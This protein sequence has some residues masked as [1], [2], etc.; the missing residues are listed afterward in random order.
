MQTVIPWRVTIDDTIGRLAPQTPQPL[1][2]DAA[3][4]AIGRLARQL[5]AALCGWHHLE[6]RLDAGDAVDLIVQVEACGPMTLLSQMSAASPM[7]GAWHDVGVLAR[8]CVDDALLS[9]ALSRLWLEFDLPTDADASTELPAPSVFTELTPDG[10]RGVTQ[11][12]RTHAAV[13]AMNLLRADPADVDAFCR[14][15][16]AMP[17]S[18]SVFAT[19]IMWSRAEPTLRMCI[20]GLEK[21]N[22]VAW[23]ETIGWPGD[24][25]RLL[26]VHQTIWET[27][28]EHA[29]R[30]GILHLD[31]R[32]GVLTPRLGFEY[33]L[34]RRSQARGRLAESSFLALLAH[35]GWAQHA[36]IDALAS[37]PGVQRVQ[38]PHLLWRSLAVR[39]VNHIKIVIDGSGAV[40]AKAYLVAGEQHA[41]PANTRRAPIQSADSIE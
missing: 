3:R 38:L 11:A 16:R 37:W 8:E 40:T 24:T 27:L 26:S 30:D 22:L 25:A 35:A 29:V 31:V 34:D 10:V 4:T 2:S 9:R 32:D 28:S 36:K 20:T 18:A 33:T 7:R 39:R 21:T 15:A 23:L 1:V 6:C 5:P 12:M 14:C 13:R 17:P 41:V 19:G